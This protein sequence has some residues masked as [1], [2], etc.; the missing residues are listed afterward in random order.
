MEEINKT[1]NRSTGKVSLPYTSINKPNSNF[2]AAVQSLARL[3]LP[4][5][6]FNNLTFSNYMSPSS[7]NAD[8]MY[9]RNKSELTTAIVVILKAPV[10]KTTDL[11]HH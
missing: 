9:K 11:P 2:V 10:L 3:F 7:N 5:P 4:P 6:S 1:E 8:K